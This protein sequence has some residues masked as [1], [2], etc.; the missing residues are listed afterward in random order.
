MLL[1]KVRIERSKQQDREKHTLMAMN[2]AKDAVQLLKAKDY[3][4]D[5]NLLN[6]RRHYLAL[7]YSWIAICGRDLH[8]EVPSTFSTTLQQWG[9]LLK[10]ITPIYNSG[11][12][13]KA[14]IQQVYDSIDD[15]DQFYDHMRMLADL[16]GVTGQHIYQICA[17]RILLKLNNGLRDINVDHVSDSIILTST[18]GRIYCDMGY[19]G[20][21]SNEFNQAKHAISTRPCNNMSEIVYRVNYSYYLACIGDYETSRE[22]FDATKHTWRHT[23]PVDS[24]NVLLTAKAYISRCM[25]LADIYSTKSLILANTD[26]FDGAIQCSTSVLQLLNKCIKVVQQQSK[27]VEK[28]KSSF[29]LENPFMPAPKTSRQEQA[30]KVAFRESQWTMAKKLGDCLV[31]LAGLHMKKG[32]WIEAQYFVNQGPLLAEKV[33][34]N[35]LYHNAYLCKSD[36]NLRCGNLTQSQEDLESTLVYQPEVNVTIY[37]TN[38]K[39]L[40]ILLVIHGFR[41]Q[42]ISWM[43]S[44]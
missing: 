31:T 5:S 28:K 30:E 18:I 44:S 19:T 11:G 6:Y 27:N 24:K 34:S 26:T 38:N 35:V 20:K 17:L 42:I 21:A 4:Q 25:L 40:K 7:A 32:S 8:E 33:N 2:C 39:M 10:K 36:F 37:Q 13:S 1:N 29:E 23:P 3:A 22:I 14:D 15:V 43:P 12:S 41:G 9:I 16:F